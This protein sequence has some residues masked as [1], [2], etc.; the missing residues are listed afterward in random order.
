VE[1]LPGWVNVDLVNLPGTDIVHDLDVAPW[2]LPDGEAIEIRAY[3][4]FE[5]VNNPLV[6]M[7]ECHR[8][9]TIGGMLRIQ[10][11]HW[12]SWT[13]YTDPTHKRFPTEY[14]FDYWV[15]GTELFKHNAAYGGVTFSKVS[16]GAAA[17]G[18]DMRVV[19]SKVAP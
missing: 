15:E 12:K 11:P 14:T 5:H 18:L 10:T 17:N 4:I 2:P 7:T 19:L 6:F 8:L 13:A 16:I 3:D 9:L 1:P